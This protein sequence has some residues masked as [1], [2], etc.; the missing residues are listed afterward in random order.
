MAQLVIPDIEEAVLQRLR[1]RAHARGTTAEAEARVVL[2]EALQPRPAAVD[3]LDVSAR[4][5]E[6]KSLK[7]GWL[8][9]TGL[10]PRPD[11]LDWLAASFDRFY[12]QELLR[13]HIYPTP[14]GGVRAEWTSGP[15]EVSVEIK[16]PNHSAE[17]HSLNLD[18]DEVEVRPLNLD[19]LND[20]QWILDRLRGLSK[21]PP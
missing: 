20:W 17:W 13:P 10:A 1:E 8:D 9:G 11:A 21:G 19:K 3:P 12:P 4:L 7:D 2:A 14:T 18:T 15:H 5:E 6:L 16:L